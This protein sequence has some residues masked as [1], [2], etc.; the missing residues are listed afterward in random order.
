MANAQAKV[1][2][3]NFR[4]YVDA[5]ETRLAHSLGLHMDALKQMIQQQHESA[6]QGRDHAHD[7]A[8]ASHEAA[9]APEPTNGNGAA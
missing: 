7:L 1:D 2:A 3:E 8:L 9:L 5:L 4:S 6:T